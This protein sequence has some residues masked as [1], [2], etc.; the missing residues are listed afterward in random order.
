MQGPVM[1]VHGVGSSHIMLWPGV[2]EE[3]AAVEVK[4][5]VEEEVKV[6]REEGEEVKGERKGE[7][8]HPG[9]KCA[10]HLIQD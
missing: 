3:V 4:V 8:K 10:H 6:E 2:H 1:L 9:H 5:R 7:R